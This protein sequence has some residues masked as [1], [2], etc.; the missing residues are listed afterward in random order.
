[1][2]NNVAS[3]IN[4]MSLAD[5][6]K[7]DMKK[8]EKTAE[9]FEAFFISRSMES[10]HEGV[11]TDGPFGGGHSEKIYRSMLL[12]EYGKVMAKSGNV[13]VKDFVMDAMIKMQEAQSYE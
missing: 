5:A 3:N 6:P 4:Y 8:A 11:K 1:M 13:G 10:M 9:D 7:F 12:D 2:M